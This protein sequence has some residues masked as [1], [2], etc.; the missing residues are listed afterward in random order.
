MN[1]SLRTDVFV[2]YKPETIATACIYLS[3][4]KLKVCSKLV[5]ME[6]GWGFLKGC[7]PSPHIVF[8]MNKH[9]YLPEEMFF[10]YPFQKILHGLMC[11]ESKRTI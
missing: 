2:R 1:D 6:M 3:A 8:T 7:T 9:L 5:Q 11:L 4:R 10:R